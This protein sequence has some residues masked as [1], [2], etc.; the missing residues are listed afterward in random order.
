MSRVSEERICEIFLKLMEPEDAASFMLQE[1]SVRFLVTEEVNQEDLAALKTS[2]EDIKGVV[3]TLAPLGSKVPSLKGFLDAANGAVEK[4][5]SFASALN[6][7]DADGVM[8]TVKQYFGGKVDLSAALKAVAKVYSQAS[9]AAT[10]VTAAAEL[11]G[12]ELADKIDDASKDKPLKDAAADAGLEPDLMK[13]AF[14]KAFKASRPGMLARMT[15]FFKNAGA[16][17]KGAEIPEFDASTFAEEAAA[18]LSLND[19]VNLGAVSE[20]IDDAPKGPLEAIG[21]AEDAGDIEG[22]DAEVE[23]EDG[24]DGD[25]DKAEKRPDFDLLAFVKEKYPDLFAALQ[26]A[27]G[28]DKAED[29]EAADQLDAA[30]ESGETS[31]EDAVEALEDEAA[32]NEEEGEEGEEGE[33]PPEEE[34]SD[35]ENAEAEEMA[36]GAGLGSLPFG[37]MELTSLLKS[38][39]DI[40]GKGNKATKSRRA[41]RIAMN[42]AAGSPIFE[43]SFDRSPKQAEVL[44][45]HLF[46]KEEDPVVSRWMRLA[47][48]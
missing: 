34:L 47:G 26:S 23:G 32:D 8:D 3:A 2:L 36:D 45:E 20:E 41:F 5:Y 35:E 12:G 17:L 38:F 22:P 40:T 9:T 42:K 15:D 27:G 46:Q 31:P 16:E 25:A 44:V 1:G 30:V 28:E 21:G 19:I 37:K 43:E 18:S 33:L 24:E 14:S 48:L 11:I 7:Q 10:T 29:K 13:Q 6:L 4:G 39:P